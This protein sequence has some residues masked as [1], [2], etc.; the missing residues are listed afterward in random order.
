MMNLQNLSTIKFMYHEE[1]VR[2]AKTIYS[3]VPRCCVLSRVSVLVY[4]FTALIYSFRDS[5]HFDF[6]FIMRI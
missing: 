4:T 3:V 2:F 1:I 6:V 5:C